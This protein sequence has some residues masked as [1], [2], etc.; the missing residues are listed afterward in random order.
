[1]KKQGC[2][3]D[4]QN[5]LKLQND[6]YF[7][8]NHPI[9]LPIWQTI[10][11]VATTNATIL[12]SGETGTGKRWF[13]NIIHT[14]S[15]LNNYDFINIDCASITT[16][17]N[18]HSKLNADARVEFTTETPD[19]YDNLLKQGTLLLENV[20]KLNLKSQKNLLELLLLIE[21]KN[22]NIRIIS[23]T[24]TDLHIRVNQGQFRSDLYYRLYVVPISVPALRY[25]VS[26]IPL[27]INHFLSI[28]AQKNNKLY[29]QATTATLNHLKQYTWL[30]NIH[31]LQNL[32]EYWSIV[33][34]GKRI[35]PHHIPTKIQR[36]IQEQQTTKI[37]NLPKEGLNLIE[38][39]TNL[40]YQALARVEYNK[41]QAARLLGISRDALNYRI[42]KHQSRPQLGNNF[43]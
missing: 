17:Q 15:Q 11:Q 39:E 43:A 31:E 35:E 6:H 34:E 23:T 16:Q 25:Y 38:M 4:W 42:K 19:T 1:M 37:F 5:A 41:T 26:D 2:L 28:F 22:L 14:N 13:A 7:V 12:L 33:Y 21:S 40:L 20:D 18:F 36:V 32:C 27:L 10:K 8:S 3:L 9:M 29:S 24:Q 30:G